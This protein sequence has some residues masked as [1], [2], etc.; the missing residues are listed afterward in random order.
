MIP[1]TRIL[2]SFVCSSAILLLSGVVQGCDAAPSPAGGSGNG[3]A[4]AESGSGGG[5]HD[6][7]LEGV[8][9]SKFQGE[10]DWQAVRASGVV[11]AFARALE[12]ETIH[13]ATFAANWRG[14]KEAGVVR[15][16]YDFYIANDSPEVQAKIFSSLVALEPGDLVPMVDIEEASL[17]GSE[18]PDLVEDF[19]RYLELVEQ[20]FGARPIVYTNPSFWNE[21]MDDSFGEYPLWVADYE[22]ESPTLPDGWQDWVIWQH[23]D[24]G[25]VPGID[26]DVDLN[27]FTG[28][29]EDLARY[30]I[31]TSDSNR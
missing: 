1:K 6:G 24:S 11:F 12:G 3:A 2:R 7:R 22:V 8:D 17:G 19:H 18:P 4:V 27:V 15:G 10:I 26:G 25:S 28:T 21:N 5:D 31:G 13:D 20:A 30:R 16:A 9:V 14:M 29:M 23:G